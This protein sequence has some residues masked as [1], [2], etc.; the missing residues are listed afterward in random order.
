MAAALSFVPSLAR[1]FLL[2]L[3]PP[4]L[5]S[6]ICILVFPSSCPIIFFSPSLYLLYS[7]CPEEL[8]GPPLL[9]F[10]SLARLLLP[11]FRLVCRRVVVIDRSTPATRKI[12]QR[13]ECHHIFLHSLFTPAITI[14]LVFYFIFPLYF[15]ANDIFEPAEYKPPDIY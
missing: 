11:F 5:P 12:Q 9:L 15:L 1:S 6:L 4:L 10:S 7:R 3:P 14:V 13:G 8:R 2:S